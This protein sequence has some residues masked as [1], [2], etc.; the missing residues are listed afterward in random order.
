MRTAAPATRPPAGSSGRPCGSWPTRDSWCPSATEGAFRTTPALP[1]AGARAGRPAGLRRAAGAGVLPVAGAAP[2]RGGLAAHRLSGSG[3]SPSARPAPATRTSASTCA[4]WAPAGRRSLADLSP[5]TTS[6]ACPAGP[7]RRPCCSWRTAAASRCCSSWCSRCCCR[8]APG[9]G[10]DEHH[11]AREVRARR[12]RRARRL[13][14]D[15]YGHRAAAGDR[16]G[17]GVA[18]ARRPSIRRSSPTPGTRSPPATASGSTICRSPSTAAGSPWP[19]QGPASRGTTGPALAAELV[20]ETGRRAAAPSRRRGPGP[21]AVPLPAGHE[22]RGGRGRRGVHPPHRRGLRRLPAARGAR[23][24]GAAE[25]GR[26]GVRLRSGSP[27]GATS[28]SSGTSWRG[29]WTGW[30]HW[31]RPSGP[32]T[33]PGGEAAARRAARALA[34]AIGA[35]S[36]WRGGRARSGPLADTARRVRCGAGA[37]RLREV[38]TELR[39]CRP[40]G[41]PTRGRRDGR[42][43]TRTTPRR[44]RWR[45]GR[46][47]SPCS[48]TG[49][50]G[51]GPAAAAGRGRRA[52]TGP[53][54]A[55]RPA[56]RGRGAGRGSSGRPRG[57]RSRR[58]GRGGRGRGRGGRAGAARD[59]ELAGARSRRPHAATAPPGPRRADPGAGRRVAS[60][61]RPPPPR[62][63]DAAAATAADRRRAAPRPTP[64]AIVGRRRRRRAGRA[65][66]LAMRPPLAASAEARPRCAGPGR[67]R[68]RPRRRAAR[69]RR[70]RLGDPQPTRRGRRRRDALAGNPPRELLGV[71]E[72]EPDTDAG[73]VERCRRRRRGGHERT[74]L[75]PTRTATRGPCGPSARA[76]CCPSPP[77]SSRSWGAGGRGHHGLLRLALPGD[78]ARRERGAIIERLRTW[79]AVCC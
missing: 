51:R 13:L 37:R 20:W 78:A 8:A 63:S 3:C 75:P 28:S 65:R 49:W 43:R 70:G 69:R 23:P 58:R 36:R 2:P 53:A 45:R 7:H 18:R 34:A 35:R 79:S 50:R 74:V 56:G 57:G 67:P 48:P 5:P 29:R 40:A 47:S 72:I 27:S 54:R 61:R 15:R 73:P 24:G 68:R 26:A 44:R 16:Q 6:S 42:R 33:A 10:H 14:V 39:R 31:P 21:R 55:A 4:A 17:L 30:A 25:A 60:A 71:E 62:A 12:R 59:R 38:T 41:W 66:R 52:G 76:G 19:L 77:R 64:A 9:R 32:R 46:P 11:R 1:G 22:R